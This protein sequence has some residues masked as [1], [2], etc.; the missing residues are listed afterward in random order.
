MTLHHEPSGNVTMDLK[1][2]CRSPHVCKK[3]SDCPGHSLV[4][5]LIEF[6]NPFDQVIRIC[7]YAL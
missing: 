6:C 1:K 2:G 7:T 4:Q 5:F 3:D